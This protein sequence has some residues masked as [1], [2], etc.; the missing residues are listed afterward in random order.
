ML[1]SLSNL[2]SVG[3]L[4]LAENI[5]KAK[6]LPVCL[7]MKLQNC[8]A[9]QKIRKGLLVYKPSSDVGVS[10]KWVKRDFLVDYSF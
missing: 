3:L 8:Y 6:W 2:S 1:L 7:S 9:D 4:F 10:S 5:Y